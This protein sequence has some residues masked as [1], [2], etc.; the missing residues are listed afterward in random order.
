[1]GRLLQA[2]VVLSALVVLWGGVVYLRANG[3]LHH[4]HGTFVGEPE[5]LT[6][7]GG[8]VR[9]AAR[10]DGRGL[11]QLGLLLLVATPVLR[12]AFS[13]VAFAIQRDRTYILF[14]AFVLLLLLTS[15][16]GHSL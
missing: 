9:S 3:P 7:V 1:M 12:V 4:E 6:H 8:I 13:L 14:T 10:L 2:G 16:V 11:I 5:E 15:L